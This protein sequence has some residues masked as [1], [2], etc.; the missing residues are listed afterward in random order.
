MDLFT[1]TFTASLF[2][3]LSTT[4]QIILFVLLLTTEKPVRNAMVYLA[5]LSGSYFLCGFFGYFAIGQLRTLLK[6][7]TPQGPGSNTQY[8]QAEFIAG[9]LM[10]VGGIG[11]FFWKKKKG[12]SGSENKLIAKLKKMNSGAALGLGLFMSVSSFPVSVPYLLVLGKCAAAQLSLSSMTGMVLFYNFG[13]ALPMLL[14]FLIYLAA[15]RGVDDIHDQL[16]QKAHLLNL[17][18]T[19]WT[20]VLFGI[21]SMI[22]SGSYFIFGV[23]LIKERYF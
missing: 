14:I 12:W 4:F 3:S 6:A 13:Y 17:H 1:L 23:A 11:Y 8:Y 10:V 20:L 16:H 18:L 15:R 9:F 5:A 19:A 2:D 7:L 21:F 22:D